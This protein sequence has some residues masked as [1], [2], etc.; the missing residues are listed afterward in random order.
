MTAAPYE[1]AKPVAHTLSKHMTSSVHFEA[2]IKQLY[3]D[4]ARIFVEMGPKHTL[5]KLASSILGSSQDVHVLAVNNMHGGSSETQLRELAVKLAVL[6]VR[7]QS[8]FDPW[9][10][11]AASRAEPLK[12]SK[13]VLNLSASTFVS[14]K[15]LKQTRSS[16]MAPPSHVHVLQPKLARHSP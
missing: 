11:T 1:A 14:K 7:F 12:K 3:A 13:T 2:Q 6:G 9:Q 16:T 15:T 4:G 10:Q 5:Q 8:V